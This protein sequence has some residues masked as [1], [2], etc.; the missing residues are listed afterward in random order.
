MIEKDK[1]NRV[2]LLHVGLCM[3]MVYKPTGKQEANLGLYP[4][5]DPNL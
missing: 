3:A 1:P 5:G 2:W 4:A